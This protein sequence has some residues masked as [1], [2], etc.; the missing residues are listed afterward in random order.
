MVFYVAVSEYET[1]LRVNVTIK[2]LPPDIIKKTSNVW[3]VG[4]RIF[5]IHFLET[6]NQF[7]NKDYKSFV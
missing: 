1:I 2:E 3:S 7:L 4:I 5:K 6:R